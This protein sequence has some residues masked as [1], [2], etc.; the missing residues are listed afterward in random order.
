MI[1]FFG[2]GGEYGPQLAK[3]GLSL[4]LQFRLTLL[5]VILEHGR[6]TNFTLSA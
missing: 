5:S 3:A 6:E 2:D 4:I 1:D